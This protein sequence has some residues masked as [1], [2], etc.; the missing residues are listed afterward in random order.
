VLEF[1]THSLFS[2][3]Q[4]L[5]QARQISDAERQKYEAEFEHQQKD[6]EEER[7]KWDFKI[8]NLF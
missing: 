2:D 1:S 3:P 6:F 5:E 8:I 4:Q 7:K